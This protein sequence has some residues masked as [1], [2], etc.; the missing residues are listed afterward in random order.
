MKTLRNLLDRLRRFRAAEA[1]VA[2]VEFA[3]ILPIMLLVYVG[4]VEAGALITMDRKIQLSSGALGDLVARSNEEVTATDLADYFQ[5]ARGIMVPYS[6][7]PLK[8]V[9]TQVLVAS[10]GK[11]AKVDWSRHYIKGAV[12]VGTDYRKGDPFTLPPEMRNIA[13]GQTVIVSETSYSYKPLFGIVF[14]QAVPLF[15]QSFYMPRFGG[16]ITLK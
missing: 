3:L 10:D 13:Q 5:A 7:D 16:T 2:A 15:R 1:G 6:A 11:S 9:V 14:D 8:Q 4:T 12:A